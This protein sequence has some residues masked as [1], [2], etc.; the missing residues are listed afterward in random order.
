V[1]FTSKG[2]TKNQ[3]SLA[4]DFSSQPG[5]GYIFYR[6]E[7]EENLELAY[8]ITIHKAQGSDFDIVFLVVPERSQILSR[9]IFYT[10]LTRFRKRLVMFVEKDIG[11]LRAYRS[12]SRSETLLRNSNLFTD[13]VRLDGVDF[14]FPEK[15][16]H[17]TKANVLVRSKSELVIANI[18]TDMGISYEY[19][20]PLEF[21]LNDFRLP[22]FTISY[23][24]KTVYWEHL[25]MLSLPTYKEDWLRKKAWYESHRLTDK[26]ITSQ[27]TPDGGINSL[28]IE[29]I[30]RERILQ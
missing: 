8:A 21:G 28:E 26:V 9:E 17:R 19:E 6:P 12:L 16:I 4:V 11:T 30:A 2:P 7:I 3:D 14:L 15:L 29:Q 24:G 22:D 27:E 13:I 20:K 23:R 18:L 5:L 25:G 10:G 1:R